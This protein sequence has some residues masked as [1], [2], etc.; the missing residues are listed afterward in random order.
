MPGTTYRWEGSTAGHS[1]IFGAEHRSAHHA[2]GRSARA[3]RRLFR[4]CDAR[5]VGGEAVV[6]SLA[7]RRNVPVG[8]LADFLHFLLWACGLATPRSGLPDWSTTSSSVPS[9]GDGYADII[10][11]RRTGAPAR[12]NE[13]D[14]RGADHGFDFAGRDG[15]VGRT[16]PQPLAHPDCRRGRRAR[17]SARSVAN[18]ACRRPVN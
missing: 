15:L 13:V 17:R 12:P 6:P 16:L 1:W 18:A 9:D 2:K 11:N 3:P 10:V 8:G 5:A 4:A 7:R 14:D